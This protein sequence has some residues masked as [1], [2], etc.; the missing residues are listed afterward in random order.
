MHR[1]LASVLAMLFVPAWASTS[2]VGTIEVNT[3]NKLF[4]V[5]W[6][7]AVAAH[8]NVVI[9]LRTS[10][11]NTP[12]TTQKAVSSVRIEPA[13]SCGDLL[14]ETEDIDGDGVLDI[15]VNTTD[16]G[17]HKSRAIFLFDPTEEEVVYAGKLPIAAEP[18]AARKYALVESQGGSLFE[19][20]FEIHD[21]K[22]KAFTQR[23]LVLDGE[24]CMSKDKRVISFDHKCPALTIT[25]TTHRPIC[26][27]HRL[28][29]P[30]VVS[31]MACKKLILPS[32]R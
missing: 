1:Y 5:H 18:I 15:A 30:H 23:E 11:L 20:L 17:L 7:C 22:I 4:F 26:I 8:E 24:V 16:T 3:K 29:V 10:V 12:N 9:S 19:S 28:D 6:E 27:D 14:F 2:S 32:S 25:A 21:K 31:K 13:E